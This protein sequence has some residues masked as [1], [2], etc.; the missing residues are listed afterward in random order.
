MI[1]LAGVKTCDTQI[2]KELEEAGIYIYKTSSGGEVPYHIIGGLKGVTFRRVWY[3]WM[4]DC[5]IPLKTAEELY[6]HPDGRKDVRVAGHCACPPP[7]EWAR[8]FGRV[9]KKPLVSRTEYEDAK[10]K[11]KRSPMYEAFAKACETEYEIADDLKEGDGYITSYHIDSQEG[12]NLFAKCI[13][14]NQ[15]P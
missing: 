13:R 12:L 6:A 8:Y 11:G 14:E 5:M 3:Y 9:S 1:N 7:A 2:R 4:V 10:E 15:L